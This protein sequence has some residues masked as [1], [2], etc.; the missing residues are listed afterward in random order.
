[1]GEKI[2]F[3]NG[4]IS[5]CQRL[6]TLTLDRVIMHTVM[7]HWSTSTYIPISLKSKKLFVDGQTYGWTDIWDPLMLLGRLGGVDLTK[8]QKCVQQSM[9]DTRDSFQNIRFLIQETNKIRTGICWKQAAKSLSESQVWTTLMTVKDKSHLKH[10]LTDGERQV[11][12]WNLFH[13]RL[14][15]RQLF[16]LFLC[17]T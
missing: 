11:A 1:M 15:G 16:Y 9:E 5:D 8:E 2:A 3:E 7:H 4:R 12:S 14:P 17:Q 10:H 13:S 6:V